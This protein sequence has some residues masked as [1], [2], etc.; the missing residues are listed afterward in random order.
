MLE[1]DKK[2]VLE[3]EEELKISFKF[4][5]NFRDKYK[6]EIDILTKGI[7]YENLTKDAVLFIEHPLRVNYYGCVDIIEAM[8][9]LLQ[10]EEVTWM[11]K[12]ATLE[13]LKHR[14]F[15]LGELIKGIEKYAVE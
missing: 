13:E 15:L 11:V 2:F 10:N 8:V 5:K 6:K 14:R 3:R 7:T 12:N 4:N 9:T 1:I